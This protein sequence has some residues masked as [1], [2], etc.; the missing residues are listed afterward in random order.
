MSEYSRG[1]WSLS[2]V[3]EWPFGILISSGEDVVVQQSGAATSTKQDTHAKHING[4]GFDEHHKDIKWSASHARNLVATQIANAR[5]IAAAP[6]L[7]EALIECAS[8]LAFNVEHSP[9]DLWVEDL[10]ACMD[11][12]KTINKALGKE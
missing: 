12:T 8:R 3:Q 4:F 7:L 11:A 1:P 2:L 10:I 9:R 5:L 6:E